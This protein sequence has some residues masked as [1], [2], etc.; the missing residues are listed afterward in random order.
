VTTTTIDLQQT[1]GRR[2]WTRADRLRLDDITREEHTLAD[3]VDVAHQILVEDGTTVIFPRIVAALHDDMLNVH[4]R[5]AGERTDAYTQAL[6]KDIEQTL[7]ELIEALE[8]AQEEQQSEGQGQDSPSQPQHPPLVPDSAE[9]KLLKSAQLRVNRRTK[10]FDKARPD[11]P[12]DTEMKSQVEKIAERQAEV[13]EMTEE[14]TE[15]Y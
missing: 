3:L 4:G 9:L 12:L 8:R 5:L 6:E 1:R 14:M 10:S 15:R 11:G 7:E 2:E 13:A